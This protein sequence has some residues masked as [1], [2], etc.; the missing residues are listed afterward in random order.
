MFLTT[1]RA[2]VSVIICELEEKIIIPS[3]VR[4]ADRGPIFSEAAPR[5]GEM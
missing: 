4:L 2:C 5:T 3:L 1:S